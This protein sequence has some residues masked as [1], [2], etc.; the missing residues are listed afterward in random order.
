[1]NFTDRGLGELTAS[2]SA[3]KKGLALPRSLQSQWRPLY[4]P[5]VSQISSPNVIPMAEIMLCSDLSWSSRPCCR[6]TEPVDIRAPHARTSGRPK[7]RRR[8]CG[9]HSRRKSFSWHTQVQKAAC[10]TVKDR[11]S[12]KLYRDCVISTRARAKYGA[13][14]HRDGFAL[15]CR[16]LCLL[17]ER[18]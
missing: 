2:R 3:L 17:T 10:R 13:S 15:W 18:I 5:V 6:R 16:P 9:C 8:R 12:N 1:V 11:I 14:C 7:G 4:A